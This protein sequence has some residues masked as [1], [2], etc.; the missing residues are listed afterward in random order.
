MSQQ[1][2]TLAAKHLTW[3]W[4]LELCNGTAS[5]QTH[6]YQRQRYTERGTKLQTGRKRSFWLQV[7]PTGHRSQQTLGNSSPGKDCSAAEMH[8]LWCHTKSRNKYFLRITVKYGD[9]TLPLCSRRSGVCCHPK[10]YH[11]FHHSPQRSNH[12]FSQFL[13]TFINQH[14]NHE[15]DYESSWVAWLC[16]Q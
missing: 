5:A 8:Y 4:L 13:F 2:R 10:I 1:I 7:L 9:V 6:T 16:G 12:C 14:D 3:V 15:N 11:E